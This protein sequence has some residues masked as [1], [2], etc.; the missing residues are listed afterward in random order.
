MDKKHRQQLNN[1]QLELLEILNKFRFSTKHLISD[2]YNT[3]N[4]G[5]DIHRR[6]T[7]LEDL[8]LVAKRYE[9]RYRLIG[10]SAAYFLTSKG[11]R[12]L[13]TAEDP[14][15]PKALD[16]KATYR[17]K[18]V[19]EPFIDYC[20]GVFSAYN[21]LSKYSGIKLFTKNE[22]AVFDYFPNPR[23]DLYIRLAD[24]QYWLELCTSGQPLAAH[25]AKIKRYI[26]YASSG[27]WEATG[28]DLP[29]VL[30]LCDSSALKNRLRKVAAKLLNDSWDTEI[31]FA[32][33]EKNNLSGSNEKIW[34]L[35]D[36]PDEL[37]KL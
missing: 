4:P 14:A 5:T 8:K 16:I 13:V 32:L 3:T 22:L 21:L 24:K 35:A 2:Y 25:I 28:T 26:E 36:D 17:N 10:K 11:V 31:T 18:T 34:Q 15:S 20:L 12:A 19:G 27:E 33:G 37:I 1:N 9:S 30:L 7:V 6:L 29:T 23:P